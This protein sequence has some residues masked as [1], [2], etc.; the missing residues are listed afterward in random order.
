MDG[1]PLPGSQLALDDPRSPRTRSR[2]RAC[3]TL[4]TSRR[5]RRQKNAPSRSSITAARAAQPSGCTW[6]RSGPSMWSL[7]TDQHLPA[8]P[9]KLIDNRYT[10]ARHERPGLHRHARH[11]LWPADRQRHRE[12]I[13]GHRR[14]CQRVRTLHPALHHEIQP[15]ELAQVS[16]SARAT[17]RHALRCSR[18]S[19]KWQVHRPEW[20]DSALADLQLHH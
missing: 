11:R 10:P 7:D 20:R 6:A 18:H 13:L 5:T 8:A 15:L 17:A 2:P 14:R 19:G 16:S 1:K 4:P 9:Y 12:G 3:S